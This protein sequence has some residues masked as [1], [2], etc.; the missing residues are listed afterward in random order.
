MGRNVTERFPKKTVLSVFSSSCYHRVLLLITLFSKH[1]NKQ[2][3][4]SIQEIR[5]INFTESV[6][7]GSHKRSLPNIL[8]LSCFQAHG[9]IALLRLGGTRTLT[10]ANTLEEK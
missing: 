3:N 8:Q 2:Q 5:K 10:L 4:V 7:S 1:G 6:N 9:R